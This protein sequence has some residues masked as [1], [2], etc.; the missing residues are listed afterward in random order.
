[1][2]QCGPNAECR[3][4]VFRGVREAETICV[5]EDGFTGDPDSKQG[6]SAAVVDVSSP[7]LTSSAMSKT[8]TGCQVN[9]STYGVGDEWFDGCEY[10]CTCSEKVEIVCQ[11][12]CK[13]LPID[14]EDKCELRPDAEDSCC[15]VMFCPDPEAMDD[16]DL[17]P[18]GLP[19]DGCLFKNATYAQGE[20]FYDGCESQ[21]QCMGYGDM[22]CLSR[23]PPT[24]PAPGQN[25]YTLP[26][27]SD[28]CCNI[29]VC[30]KPFLDPS[31]NVKK[32]E[33]AIE[34]VMKAPES[35]ADGE[36]EPPVVEV[37]QLRETTTEREPVKEPRI[38][39]SPEFSQPIPGKPTEVMLFYSS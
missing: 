5:C 37:E 8:P 38:V 6:C 22:V 15:K 17:K 2:F 1:M 32:E 31:Q 16:Q 18:V 11:P 10:K 4:E 9:N 27:A 24:A 33:F 28:P 35:A 20:R 21:C 34:E 3:H 30:D 7:T 23:C 26:D 13:P 29:T 25:C 19:F 14:S 12:R 39:N 36:E